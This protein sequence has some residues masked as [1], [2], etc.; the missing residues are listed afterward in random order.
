MA[1]AISLFDDQSYTIFYCSCGWHVRFLNLKDPL[2]LWRIL[3]H[4]YSQIH[5]LWLTC[6]GCGLVQAESMNISRD[7]SG[8]GVQQALLKMLEG[9]VMHSPTP[10][11][12]Y[13]LQ[14]S[15]PASLLIVCQGD[16][17]LPPEICCQ[18]TTCF[19]K[20]LVLHTILRLGQAAMFLLGAADDT[21]Q[22]F[23]FRL[24]M[25]QRKG[26]A[27]IHEETI[28]RCGV[29]SLFETCPFKW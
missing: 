5:V 19:Q 13:K 7:V 21:K 12:I 1:P 25:Y 2:C 3:V 4:M 9:T 16:F 20:Q 11:I 26:H 27:N 6:S 17:W 28:F 29:P 24:W 23:G 10:P 22:I 18:W 15:N 14:L 8:E